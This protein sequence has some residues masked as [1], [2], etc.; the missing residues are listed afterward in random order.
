MQTQRNSQIKRME[1]LNDNTTE[2]ELES[3][4]I[5]RVLPPQASQMALRQP[6]TV[7]FQWGDDYQVDVRPLVYHGNP[8]RIVGRRLVP[9]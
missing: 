2:V 8:K 7:T 5:F 1:Y 3:G 9:A 6:V 4:E